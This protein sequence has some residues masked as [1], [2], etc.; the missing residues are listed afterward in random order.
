MYL[1]KHFEQQ[2]LQELHTLIRQYPLATLITPT[3][4][5]FEANHI[6]MYLSP[7]P[8]PW[9]G[10]QA[11]VARSNPLLNHIDN[12]NPQKVLAIFH[13]VNM[14]ITPSW[15]ATKQET[16]EVVPTWN[17]TVVHAHGILRKIEDPTWLHRLLTVLTEQQESAFSAPW[18]VSDAPAAFI[19]ELLSYIV[20]LELEI[21]QLVGKWKVSQNQPE[22]NQHSVLQALQHHPQPEATPMAA[23]IQRYKKPAQ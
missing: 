1:P 14:Y 4:Q 16:G 6:P 20:G 9:G 13:G 2:D 22:R 18:H 5:G 10:L 3:P 21:T 17:Y 15:Y 7:D 19:E 11:H 23:W 12:S 8:K